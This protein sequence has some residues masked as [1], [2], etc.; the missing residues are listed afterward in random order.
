MSALIR[1]ANVPPSALALFENAKTAVFFYLVATYWLK[2]YRHARARGV[3]AS[4]KEIY[5]WVSQVRAYPH[6]FFSM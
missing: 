4:A 1:R 5:T 2:A 3:R 6:E